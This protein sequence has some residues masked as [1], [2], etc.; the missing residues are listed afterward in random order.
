MLKEGDI[1][2]LGNGTHYRVLSVELVVIKHL[3]HGILERFLRGETFKEND[4]W[5]PEFHEYQ[6]KCEPVHTSSTDWNRTII[7]SGNEFKNRKPIG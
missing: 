3:K 2:P 7:L 6:I 5:R 4:W 1:F